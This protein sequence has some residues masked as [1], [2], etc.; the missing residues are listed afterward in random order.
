MKVLIISGFLGAG[1]TTFIKELAQRTR[2]DF[3]VLENEYGEVGIDG[4][5]LSQE[6]D[7]PVE[8]NVWELTEGCV[9]CSMKQD[10]ATSIITIANALDPEYLVVE[11][12]GVGVLSRVID[13]IKQIGYDKIQLLS[14]ITVLDGHSY[15]RYIS[16]FADIY[17]DQV[18]IAGT[19]VISKMEAASDD[20]LFD[21][22]KKIRSQNPDGEIVSTHYSKKDNEWWEKLLSTTLEG[23]HILSDE[24]DAPDLENI[25]LTYV[26]LESELQL[27]YMLENLL[28]G[29]YGNIVRAKGYLK[30]GSNWVRFDVADKLYGIT[31]IEPMADSRAV[32]IGQNIKRSLLR[33]LLQK[34][35]LIPVQARESEL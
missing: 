33:E 8:M 24:V 26:K 12:T 19:V 20:E 5:L 16:E 29:A 25:G 1:K 7:R 23:E 32:F 13:N 31:G 28:R 3:V 30:T 6:E 21:L 2:K 9:C 35:I 15:D 34:E 14:P 10:F 18:A 22:E 17:V 4:P 27:I 11:P